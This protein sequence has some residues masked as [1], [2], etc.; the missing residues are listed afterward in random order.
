MALLV[1]PMA[2]RMPISRVR[3][4][5]ETS[6]MLMMPTAPRPRVTMP[7]PPR[8]RSMASQ[9]GADHVLFLD[10]IELFKSVFE[11]GVEA[12][13][14][15]D[16]VMDGGSGQGGVSLES[17][18]VLDGGD[19]VAGDVFALHGEEFLHGGEGM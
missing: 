11:G 16:D 1:A 10:G 4:V 3:S 15:G 13:V 8:K 12:V 2:L 9:D 18:L 14:A 7:T 19:G 6:M 17:G 5:T